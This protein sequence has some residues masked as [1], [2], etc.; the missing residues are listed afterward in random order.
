M[1]KLVALYEEILRALDAR[2]LVREACKGM[3]R[4]PLLL[5]LGKAAGE[6]AE[7]AR[8]ALG[9]CPGVVALKPDAPAPGG[10]RLR[11]FRGDHPIPDQGSLAAGEALLLAA[12]AADRPVLVLVSGGGSALAEV[13]V[14]SVSLQRLREI[15]TALV[16]S[17]AP[18]EEV[19]VVRKHLSRLKGG[20]LARALHA[21]GL[22][23]ARALVAVDVPLGGFPSVASGPA[24]ADP[25]TRA[26]AV[27]IARRLGLP[28]LPFIET[29]K[30]GEPADLVEHVA[31]C[32]MRSAA[33]VAEQQGARILEAPVHGPLEALARKF[34]QAR[35]FAVASGEPDIHIPLSAPPGGR[36]QH[37]ALLMARA[38]RGEPGAAFLAAG[39]DGRDGATEA[40]GALVTGAT[41]DAAV[42]RGLDPERALAEFASTRVLEALGATLPAR[43]TGAHAGDV[44]LLLRP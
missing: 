32:D 14:D 19:N 31:I 17:G 30:P 41:W 33:L 5:A 25:S 34:E 43:H 27:E 38:L 9:D 16:R 13:P 35:G 1:E 2:R 42:S 24:A 28:E 26:E 11:V 18:I 3:P 12:R 36:S 10:T 15:N 39:T 20:G 8:D 40:A 29:L 4:A 21:A 7:G 6:M 23:T 37:L 22:K 44:F